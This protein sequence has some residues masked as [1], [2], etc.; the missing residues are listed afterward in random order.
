VDY[1]KHETQWEQRLRHAFLLLQNKSGNKNRDENVLE[2]SKWE[3]QEWF[4][5]VS[6]KSGKLG[7]VRGEG[8]KGPAMGKSPSLRLQCV[9]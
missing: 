9:L 5:V 7:G 1:L 2:I 8:R 6:G 4:S 3:D